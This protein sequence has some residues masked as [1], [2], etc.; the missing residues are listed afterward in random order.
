MMP[1]VNVVIRSV[2]ERTENA[3][4]RVVQSQISP[5]S[6]VHIIRDRPFADAHIDSVRW[7]TATDG[8]WSLF[9]DADVLLR[10][11][12]I[13]QMLREA[14]SISTPFY[15]LNFRV[16]DRGFGGPA[17]G[18]HL[19]STRH[20]H[21]ALQ[22]AD[23]ARD[24]QR[25]ES[26]MVREMAK[27]ERVPSLSSATIAGI[28]GYEQSYRDVY[29]T[30]F[31]RAV[32]FRRH[33]NYFLRLYR[34]HYSDWEHDHDYQ[35]MLWGLLDGT[36]Y[37]LDHQ[38]APLES[39]FYQD[40]AGQVLSML[41]I[42]EK[43]PYVLDQD[44]LERIVDEHVSDEWYN[45]YQHRICPSAPIIAAVPDR[46]FTTRVRRSLISVGRRAKRVINVAV[47]G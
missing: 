33:H 27:R 7:A 11:D 35:V 4:V 5:E 16:L 20:L 1:N 26:R 8:A 3:C 12:A 31:V 23:M 15:M 17:Y 43:K 19:Y 36:I 6:R 24:D 9:L 37:G 45:S 40:K 44:E 10:R 25:P 34:T 13:A 30:A 38:K 28:H 22:F 29:R 14:E 42:A 39:G 47:Y 41:S 2:G 32:K 21:T 18:V 46:S